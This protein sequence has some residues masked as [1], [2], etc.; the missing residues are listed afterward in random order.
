MTTTKEKP[1][2]IRNVIETSRRGNK[3]IGRINVLTG[4]PADDPKTDAKTS[5]AKT[6]RE[7]TSSSASGSD[8]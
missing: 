3:V 1:P 6:P 8:R 2:R 4:K 5:K 7:P